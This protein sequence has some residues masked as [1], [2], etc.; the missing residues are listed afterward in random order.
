MRKILLFVSFALL[1]S[2]VSAESY[3]ESMEVKGLYGGSWGKFIGQGGSGN[4]AQV[5]I[6]TMDAVHCTTDF[7]IKNIGST[8]SVWVGTSIHISSATANC[9][10]FSVDTLGR[11]NIG[12]ELKPGQDITLSGRS[13]AG[14]YG[15]SNGDS[16]T[17]QALE[18]RKEPAGKIIRE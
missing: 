11:I 10:H 14:W 2:F 7:N 3:R 12:R 1:V 13:K 9:R 16:T 17:V 6:S 15:I 5:I 4:L 18:T 8:Y